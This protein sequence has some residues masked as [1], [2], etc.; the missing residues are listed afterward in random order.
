M[1]KALNNLEQFHDKT[2]KVYPSQEAC[3][4]RYIIM[5]TSSHT[6]FCVSYPV[7]VTGF[8]KTGLITPMTVGLIFHHVH[9][10]T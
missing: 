7:I 1:G 3:I 6:Q 9:D 4:A 8:A 2:T 5:H 10:N